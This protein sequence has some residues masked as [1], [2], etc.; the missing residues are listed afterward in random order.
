M[1]KNPKFKPEIMRVKLNPEQA[2]LSCACYDAGY[3]YQ[4]YYIEP[5]MPTTFLGP[6]NVYASPPSG[7]VCIIEYAGSKGHYNTTMGPSNVAS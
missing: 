5:E 1:P 3:R 4:E 7:Q 6:K 2:V